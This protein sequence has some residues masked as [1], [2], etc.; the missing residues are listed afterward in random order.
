MENID[1]LVS[2]IKAN[3]DDKFI[4]IIDF[5]E[6]A[7]LLEYSMQMEKY[8]DGD[9]ERE[10]PSNIIETAYLKLCSEDFEENRDMFGEFFLQ[11]QNYTLKDLRAYWR[12]NIQN[13]EKEF[14]MRCTYCNIPFKYCPMKVLGYIK[15]V[16][17]ENNINEYEF[18]DRLLD[19]KDD[20]ANY[21]NNEEDVNYIVSKILDIT[22]K[23]IDI[24]GI[25]FVVQTDSVDIIGEE[26]GMLKFRN[27]DFIC[28][29]ISFINNLNDF[30]N[31]KEGIY[32]EINLAD[33]CFDEPSYMFYKSPVKITAYLKYLCMQRNV[34]ILTV[35]TRLYT[36]IKSDENV[37]K[38]SF[39]NQYVNNVNKLECGE[40]VKKEIIDIVT[41]MK[42][43]NAIRKVPY[44]QFNL[45]LYTTNKDVSDKII[46]ILNRTATEFGYL[47]NTNTLFVDAEMLIKR[48][49]D[50]NDV[51]FQ[52]DK[53]CNDNSFIVF[54]NVDKIK[55]LNEFRVDTFFTAI[56]KFIPQTK[57][58]MVILIGE[59]LGLSSLLEMHPVLNNYV[60]HKKI[61]ICEYDVDIIKQKVYRRI[62]KFEN[63]D[64]SFK[65]KLD[66]YIENTYKL[67]IVDENQYMQDLYNDIMFNKYNRKEFVGE[68]GQNE[69]PDLVGTRTVEEILK[70][71]QNLV[72]VDEVKRKIF[73][74]LRYLE[75][76]KKADVP[77]FANLNMVFK[78]NS[79]TGKTTVA[80]LYAELFYK[81]GFIKKN[82]VI[83]VT[84][85]D[86]IGDHLGQTALKTQ[87]V[88][89]TAL[90]GVLFIDEAYSIMASKGTADY[91]AECIAT[92]CKAM[93]TYKDRLVIIFAGYTREMNDFI[94]KNQG[95]MSR[96]GSEIEFPDFSVDELWQIFEDEAVG[97]GF[98]LEPAV[99]GKV[100]KLIEKNKV[101]RNFG[102]ARFIINLFERLVITHA[103]EN[104]DENKLKV[105]TSGDVDVYQKT[106]KQNERGMDDILKDLNSLIGIKNIKDVINGFISVLELNSKLDRLP[107]FN[108][109]M[110]FKGNAGTGKT[111]VA[112]LLAEVYFNL[113][114]IRKNKL[115]EVQA[116]DLIGEYIGQTGPKTKAVI[117]SA[118][119]GV[120]F[121]D[122]AY[123]IMN[124]GGVNGSYTDECIS[125]LLKAM[126]DYQGRL[127]II[128]AGYKEEM[129]RFRDQ[130][131]GLKSRV[132]FELDF[133]DYS[134]D[135]LMEIFYKK[136]REKEYNFDPAAE[137]KVRKILKNAKSV[138]NF[139]NGRFVENLIQKIIVE[140]AV[141]T[142][143][144]FDRERLLLITSE[145][146]KEV[147]AE[148]SKSKIGFNNN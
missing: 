129:K 51:F 40:N 22:N 46:N 41:Y 61:D 125:T 26:A 133:P 111:T 95:L 67:K 120:L 62:K 145:D 47:Q 144:V 90:D 86:L 102:N 118:V 135:E 39:Y 84:S 21:A 139:G 126:E 42:N 110:I 52:M 2:Y 94:N 48:T 113:G 123:S 116:Q 79:G 134:I 23:K 112:R 108:M 105:I 97:N 57:K 43:Y 1:S 19:I 138:D 142:K 91:P 99:E 80:R 136:L 35:L 69:I 81:L 88:I 115:V 11:Y 107:E 15:K 64:D 104:E 132:G 114:Y 49:K 56:E 8:K 17:A 93:D 29:N 50:N 109:H 85:K 36:E 119:D 32:Q 137:E 33:P 38:I 78:G 143:G 101:T 31:R 16:I 96:V 18:F 6:R 20:S 59:K 5:M 30:Y 25:E 44:I 60:I 87:K 12:F 14:S 54:T 76:T 140:H 58:C 66:S 100:R 121:I 4:R 147:K 117:E 83:E 128:F 98:E 27:L 55:M 127:I 10:R 45:A 13:L 71:F 82:T 92:L 74:I 3:V 122:E 106:I 75:Y 34:D 72:G 65:G 28:N 148:E 130:N 103:T 70:D 131:P 124:H 73:E 77:E 68:I 7:N 9:K 146:I 89:E 53:I 63:I 24:M 141:N 37:A